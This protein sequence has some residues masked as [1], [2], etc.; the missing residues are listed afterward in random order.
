VELPVD[1][2][3]D[4]QTQQKDH[5]A[6]PRVD[7]YGFFG[8][9]RLLTSVDEGTEG[10]LPLTTTHEGQRFA[11]ASTNA[12]MW[13]EGSKPK[14]RDGMAGSGRSPQSLAAIKPTRTW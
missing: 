8:R 9:C 10:P 3:T 2:S 14:G 7:V 1:E 13:R 6:G 4:Y 12:G 11:H 5:A